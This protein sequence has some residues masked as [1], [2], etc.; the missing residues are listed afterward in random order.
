MK[1]GE[2]E[3]SLLNTTDISGLLK[4]GEVMSYINILQSHLPEIKRIYKIKYFG[5]FGSYVKNLHR[6]D[7]DLDILVEFEEPPSLFKLIELENALTDLLHVSVDIA[8]KD[9]LKPNIAKH[10]MGEVISL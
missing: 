2:I 8:I 5:V 1:I 4:E 10:I 6:N 7:S 3:M 9:D